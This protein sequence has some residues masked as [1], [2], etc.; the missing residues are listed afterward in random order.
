MKQVVFAALVLYTGNMVAQNRSISF[1]QGV[2]N[3]SIN[4]AKQENKLIFVDCY[5]SWCGPCKEMSKYVF[6]KDTVADFFNSRFVNM[7]I[8]MEKGEGPALGKEFHVEAYPTFLL[9]NSERKV[10]YRLVGGMPADTFLARINKGMDPANEVAVLN[11]RYA[12]GDRSKALLR[13]YIPVKI[14]GMELSVGKKMAN[15]YFDMLTPQE[16][17]LPENWFLFGENRYTMYISSLHSR[18]FSYL[19]DHWKDFV[20]NNGQ[21][22][23]ENKLRH[24]YQK[25]AEYTLR[26][27]YFKGDNKQVLPYDKKEFEQYKKQIKSTRLVDKD[28]LLALMDISMA[29]GEKDTVR[30]TQLMAT[31]IGKMSGENQH[32]A[33]AYFSMF[34]ASQLRTNPQ[35]QQIVDSIIQSNQSENLVRY[36]KTLK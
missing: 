5:T 17:V 2:L 36:V 31:Y 32:V 4:K 28:Q 14:N 11:E 33:F 6:T 27:W 18:T 8:D 24:T 3:E 25:I 16:R 26:G 7:Q 12:A 9:L 35:M 13:D 30:L 29:A 20:K 10:V 23:V 15:D 22:A 1:E 21:E 19:A 34:P